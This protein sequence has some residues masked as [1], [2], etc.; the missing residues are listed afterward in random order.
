M[1][2]DDNFDT[3]NDVELDA[4]KIAIM[5]SFHYIFHNEDKLELPTYL[6]KYSREIIQ[7][8]YRDKKEMI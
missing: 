8:Y 3:D 1:S 7:L 6:S 4:K 5:M 2:K